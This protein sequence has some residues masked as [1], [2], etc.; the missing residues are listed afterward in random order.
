MSVSR[1]L[2]RSRPGFTLIELLVVIAIIAI[3]IALL[4]PAVQKVRE[5]AARTQ[6][7]NNMKQLGVA[8]HAS[9]DVNKRL[10]AG[11]G[12]LTG[13]THL[14]TAFILPYIEQEPLFKQ[15]DFSTGGAWNNYAYHKEIV[16]IYLCPAS[17]RAPTLNYDAAA[18]G[19]T[20][21]NSL[22]IAEY[23]AIAGSDGARQFTSPAIAATNPDSSWNST[24]PLGT[25]YLNS[26]TKLT[27]ITDGTSNTMLVGEFSGVTK[28][29]KTND[30]QGGGDDVATWDGYADT[31]YPGYVLRMIVYPPNSAVFYNPS[32]AVANCSPVTTGKIAS[33]ALKS[34]HPGGV[35]VLLAD[36]S[37]RMILDS[38]NIDTYKNLADRRDGQTLGE[39]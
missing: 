38:I 18:P 15:I 5:A 23:S 2:H 8:L 34:M 29:Q 37:V 14:W 20:Y 31:A 19:G 17:I 28:C 33:A 39:F 11:L 1:Y 12:N 36:G 22:A 35:N 9:H 10:P 27:E 25:M 6:C 13:G 3:L 26:K 16:R 4:V 24:S 21:Y 30:Y 7:V 32:L